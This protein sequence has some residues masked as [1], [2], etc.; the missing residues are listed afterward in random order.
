MLC[1]VAFP[2]EMRNLEQYQPVITAFGLNETVLQILPHVMKYYKGNLFT[3]LWDRKGKELD[4][5][6]II[7]EVWRPTYKLWSDLCGRLKSGDL[8]F[9]E[10]ERYFQTA[11][12]ETLRDDLMKLCEDGN[13]KWINAR[14]DQLEKYR[15]LQSCIAYHMDRK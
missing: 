8:K 11:D 2:K 4:I 6:E 1:K 14:L 13:N 5:E 12:I 9:S 3:I 15:N 10:C 7:L